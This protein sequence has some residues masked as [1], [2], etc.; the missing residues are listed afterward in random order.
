VKR[1][2]IKMQLKLFGQCYC[3]TSRRDAMDHL[4]DLGDTAVA[5]PTK[6]WAQRTANRNERKSGQTWYV[7][8]WQ[9]S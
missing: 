3:A 9:R 5:V 4:R 8:K 2:W 1:R 6:A 7:T